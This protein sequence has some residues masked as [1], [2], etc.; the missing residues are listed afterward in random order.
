MSDITKENQKKDNLTVFRKIYNLN[1]LIINY[2]VIQLYN[3][4]TMEP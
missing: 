1:L 4:S 2:C 3:N